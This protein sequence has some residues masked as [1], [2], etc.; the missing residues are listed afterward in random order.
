M[1]ALGT[2]DKLTLCCRLG[3]AFTAGHSRVGPAKLEPTL[4]T[5][6]NVFEFHVHAKVSYALF[7]KITEYLSNVFTLQ[8]NTL[9]THSLVYHFFPYIMNIQN[10]ESKMNLKEIW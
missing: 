1:A 9:S 8:L 7:I 10:R 5:L 3:A 2:P 6:D 4:G